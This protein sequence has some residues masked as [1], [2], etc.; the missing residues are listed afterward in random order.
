[1]LYVLLATVLLATLL[2][3]VVAKGPDTSKFCAPR[4]PGWLPLIGHAHLLPTG[5][6]LFPVLEKW[7]V[8]TG[9][10]YVFYIGSQPFVLSCG[11][12]YVK[13]VLCQETPKSYIY[14][15][16]RPWLADGLLVSSGPK[17]KNRRRLLTPAFHYD[18]LQEFSL[19]FSEQADV[20]ARKWEM[21]AAQ[22]TA[23]V[24]LMNDVTALTLDIIL[25]TAMGCRENI[26]RAENNTYVSAIQGITDAIIYRQLSPWIH[27]D[28]LFKLSQTG[29]KH[30]ACLAIIHNF[31]KDV[32]AK[33]R[34]QAS[35]A[36]SFDTASKK[37]TFLDVLLM[38][39]DEKG[40]QL[41]DADIAEEVDTFMFEGHDTTASA[42]TWAI[43]LFAKHPDVQKKAQEE[44]D[45]VLR[46]K[47]IASLEDVSKME[48]LACCTKEALRVYPP[49]PIYARRQRV[50]PDTDPGSDPT[51]EGTYMVSAWHLHRNPAVWTNPDVFDPTRHLPENSKGRHPFAM[52]PF[53]AGPRNCIGQK[54]AMDEE[55]IVLATLLKR[56]SFSLV[57]GLEE[58]APEMGLIL[59]P[60]GHKLFINVSV[61]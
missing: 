28:F 6:A 59:R 8:L 41:S 32:I 15:A 33:R 61:R 20:L 54:F 31:R 35:I 14:F 40:E 2:F 4:V 19:I 50:R 13:E 12:D 49:V 26:Q 34:R 17:W 22:G 48:Y 24:E 39:R 25:E 11:A 30:D 53:S 7:R 45:A 9:D 58:P 47:H 36:D 51:P 10:R 23:Q 21:A 38:A 1:M 46:D 60:A 29:R 52:V 16:M 56:L 5:P 55:K 44:V 37:R 3:H 42:L 27:P 57:P 43:Y 18:I